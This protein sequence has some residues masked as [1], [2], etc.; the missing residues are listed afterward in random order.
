MTV[1]RITPEAGS[2]K[3][4]DFRD[5]PLHR[6]LVAMGFLEFVKNAPAGSLFF[7]GGDRDAK[8]AAN[9]VAGRVLEWLQ[10][11]GLI[12]EGVQPNHAWRHRMKTVCDELGISMRTPDTIQAHAPRTSGESYGDVTLKAKKRAIDALPFYRIERQQELIAAYLIIVLRPICSGSILHYYWLQSLYLDLKLNRSQQI[13]AV[14]QN[15][16]AK[17]AEAGSPYSDSYPAALK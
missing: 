1:M 4:S 9:M 3:S 10:K 16:N 12:P 5:V 11:A 17:S 7:K 6:Q 14:T 15:I 2:V 8:A 13:I